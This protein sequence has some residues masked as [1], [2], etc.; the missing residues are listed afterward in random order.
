MS[1]EK[2]DFDGITLVFMYIY[3]NSHDISF[4]VNFSDDWPEECQDIFA[5]FFE[6]KVLKHEDWFDKELA[7]KDPPKFMAL[8]K[9][10]RIKG[11]VRFDIN[12]MV[13]DALEGV[14]GENVALI[15]EE[16]M[17]KLDLNNLPDELEKACVL[18]N[19]F[20]ENKTVH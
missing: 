20:N 18:R 2:C 6:G 1:N 14:R 4:N 13:D 16:F 11:V 19:K 12:L 17:K 9:I 3:K 15:Y 5:H 10:C 7:A 8:T